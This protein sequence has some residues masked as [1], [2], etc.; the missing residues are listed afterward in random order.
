MKWQV[1]TEWIDYDK[2]TEIKEFKDFIQ[3]MN[4]Q[5][6]QLKKYKNKIRSCSYQEIKGE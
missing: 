1:I 5:G 4:Y 3:A 2:K 6:S